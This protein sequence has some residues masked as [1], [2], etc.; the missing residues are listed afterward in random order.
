MRVIRAQSTDGRVFRSIGD[1]FHVTGKSPGDP[2]YYRDFAKIPVIGGGKA[3]SLSNPYRQSVWVQSAIGQVAQPLKSVSLKFYRGEKEIVDP[4]LTTW[5]KK[6]AKGLSY[7]EWLDATT[8]WYKLAGECF[9]V[10]DDTWLVSNPK[11]KRSKLLVVRP[12]SM[13]HIVQ[14]DELI[15]WELKDAKG[16]AHLLLPE[17]VIQIKRWNPNN[18]Y[19][20]LGEL[21]SALQAAETDYLAGK[22][23]RD[24]FANMGDHG[25]YV[26]AKAGMP[27]DAQR[28]QIVSQLRAKREARLRG[29]FRPVFLTSDIEVKSPQVTTP[30]ASFVATRLG[31]RHEVYIAFGV[32]PSMADIAVSYSIGSASDYFRLIFNTCVPLGVTIAGGI[33]LL[34]QR[35]TGY[36]DIEGYFDWDEHPVMQ[37]VRAERVDSAHKL[38]TMGMPLKS[39]GEYLDMGLP[40]FDG[41]DISYL[42]FSVAPV[43][44]TPLP[45]SDPALAESESRPEES[46]DDAVGAMLKVLSGDCTA[47]RSQVPTCSKARDPR[48][49]ASWRAMMAKRRETVK[50]FESKFGR[51]LMTA[52]AEVLRNIERN[53][54]LIQN[55]VGTRKAVA[56]DFTFDLTKFRGNLISEMRKVAR[57]ALDSAGEQLLEEVG[58]E[59]AFS[60][61][62]ARA[63]N[64]LRERENK[65]SNIADEIFEDVKG[66]IEES[67]RE[68]ESISDM[69]NR[70]R[71]TFS[72]ISKARATRI[73]MTET[74]VAY[75][76]A[77]DEA[78]KQVG[79]QYKQWLTSGNDNVRPSHLAAEEQ[80]VPLDEPFQVGGAELMFPGDPDGPAEEVINCHCVQIAVT[81]DGKAFRV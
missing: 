59:D 28:E 50:A 24:T 54:D 4:A 76:V 27:T 78:M 62:P 66:S 5:W 20:G 60:M 36:A 13:R 71:S 49:V 41:D 1:G 72:G 34:V 25:D 11:A 61:P 6:P 67:L 69:S 73:A 22:Y 74:S 8:G 30:D 79:V 48:R 12:D 31:N 17:Q 33:D 3:A 40:R 55:A 16:R 63:M 56:A 43:G 10:L 77:R 46:A 44:E 29:E 81:E 58:E 38:W 9:W 39:I 2:S 64:F 42:P 75:G 52:R 23:S 68:G 18:P 47:H 80:T 15:G 57:A 65:L 32:P 70:I 19:R 21:D 14:D 26:I 7:E 35:Q 37:Q 53:R 51:V 45:E